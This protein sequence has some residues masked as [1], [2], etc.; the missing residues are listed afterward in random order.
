MQNAD[1]IKKWWLKSLGVLFIVNWFTYSLT[2]CSKINTIDIISNLMIIFIF[3][4]LLLAIPY[5][6]FYYFAYKKEGTKFLGSQLILGPII[7]LLGTFEEMSTGFNMPEL[8]L[9]LILTLPYIFWFVCSY[10]L[11]RLNRAKKLQRRMDTKILA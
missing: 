4:P 11:Y 9:G 2:M 5:G 10:R 7:F 8:F 3:V 6:A 1:Q